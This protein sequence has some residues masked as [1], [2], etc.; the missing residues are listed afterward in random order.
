MAET[1]AATAEK[2]EG[3]VRSERWPLRIP[4]QERDLRKPKVEMRHLEVWKRNELLC[5]VVKMMRDESQIGDVG[6]KGWSSA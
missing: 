2:A 3:V 1:S 5:K 6:S 4:S